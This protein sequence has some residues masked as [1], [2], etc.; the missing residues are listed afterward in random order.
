MMLSKSG[1]P[2]A[3]V[4]GRTVASSLCLCLIASGVL[5][6][7][8]PNAAQ[9]TPAPVIDERNRLV[10]AVEA[11]GEGAVS[12]LVNALDSEWK[13][14]RL[15]AIHLLADLG[16]LARDAL[17]AGLISTHSDVRYIAAGTLAEMPGVENYI[18]TFARDPELAVRLRFYKDIMPRHLLDDGKP[19]EVLIAQLDSAY[20]QARGIVRT[21]IIEA[22]AEMPLTEASTALLRRAADMQKARIAAQADEEEADEAEKRALTA[23]RPLL[24]K[25]ITRARELADAQQWEQLIEELS[26]EEVASWPAT[27][28]R[29]RRMGG[30]YVSKRVEAHYRLA[31][32]HY[33]LGRGEEAAEKLQAIIDGG[34]GISH[35][36]ERRFYSHILD[37]YRNNYREHLRG[38]ARVRE[39][40]GQMALD[41]GDRLAGRRNDEALESYRRLQDIE[42]LSPELTSRARTAIQAL[43]D[44]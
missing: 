42:G 31:T 13:V 30:Y 3:R 7:A 9:T 28:G 17:E 23:L 24:E 4:P 2:G 33:E 35:I 8:N 6:A 36:R 40:Y 44:S 12:K 32:A 20:D 21:E 11:E 18:K 1:K 19:S 16:E 27:A 34:L 37:L 5:A 14:M 41:Y 29:G 22:V 10:S 39:T 26:Q 43:D 25:T 38:D 15:T